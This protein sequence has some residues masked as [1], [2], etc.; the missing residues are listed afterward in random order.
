MPRIMLNILRI[1][2]NKSVFVVQKCF[3]LV[4]ESVGK[5]SY[6]IKFCIHN[7]GVLGY[8]TGTKTF[9]FAPP[10]LINSMNKH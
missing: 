1:M 3:W 2:L 10:H 5:Y 4:C 9:N 6:S 8:N 7:D